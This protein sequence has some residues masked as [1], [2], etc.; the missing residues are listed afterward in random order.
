[1]GK[2][3]VSGS[4]YASLVCL[5][6]HLCASASASSSSPPSQD[7]LYASLLHCLTNHSNSPP[8]QLSNTLF[9]QT[10]SS[11]SS[12][13][14]SYIR[15]ARFNT[16]STPKPSFILTPLQPSHVQAAVICSK[17][18][19]I[20]LRI[21]SGGHDYEGISYL[22][23][24]PFI[25][26]DL[27]NLRTVTVDTQKEIAVIQ[28]GATLGE[29]YYGI[30]EKSKVHG[31]PAGLCPTVGVGGHF[32][33]GGYGSLLRKYGLS[34]DQIIDAQIVD[35]NGRILQRNSMGEDLFWAIRG[36]GGASFGV[37]L[38]YTVKLV[39]VPETVTVFKVRKTLEENATDV[40][41]QW[42]QVAPHTD[43]RLFM[44]LLLQPVTVKK[45]KTIRVSVLGSFLGRANEVVTLME[46]EFP[47]LGLKKEDC[48]EMGWIDSM[49][50]WA[51]LDNDTNARKLLDRNPDSAHFLKRKSDY[52]QTPIPKEGLENIWKK[53]IELGKTGF[54]FNPYGG[55]MNE[56]SS[57][58]TPFPHRAGNLY[59]IQY[60]VNWEE[61]GDEADKN[62]TNQI[63]S[64]YSYMTPFVSKNPRRAFLNYRDLDIGTNKFDEKSYEEGEVYGVKYFHENFQRLVKIKTEVDPENF[65]RNQQS[66]PVLSRL[67][68]GGGRILQ[69]SLF[70][71]WMMMVVELFLCKPSS[72]KFV[73]ISVTTFSDGPRYS[74]VKEIWTVLDEDETS[75]TP[76]TA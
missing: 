23:H 63:R 22:A 71:T 21:R 69:S 14:R 54:V 13:L 34:V 46:K 16:S 48:A 61:P 18:I 40:V 5:L 31:F 60:S 57:D 10:N 52:V 33:G 7:S 47:L 45:S 38:S 70:L 2:P 12:I 11:Y 28:A 56:I 66:I 19:P 37:I 64:L 44:R 6:L 29:V 39:S 67:E 42:Q 3:G 20:P 55:K 17:T 41:V 26:L 62:Y 65:F 30:W 36:G 75:T 74:P 43:D 24:E 72:A 25:I 50:W 76:M 15:N 59:K 9:S 8:N 35:V 27:F 1:M 73:S 49:V 53:M 32:S 51:G 4:A 68:S 58:A